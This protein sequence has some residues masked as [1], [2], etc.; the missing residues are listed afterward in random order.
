MQWLLWLTIASAFDA[1]PSTVAEEICVEYERPRRLA[2]AMPPQPPALGA[3]IAWV[4]ARELLGQGRLPSGPYDAA[5]FVSWVPQTDPPPEGDAPVRL[6]V[7][8][9]PHP[10]EPDRVLVRVGAAAAQPAVAEP[11]HVVVLVSVAHTMRSVSTR[12][13]P[14][15]Q[16]VVPDPAAPTLLYDRVDR[17][18]LAREALRA[19]VADLPPDS[20]L[21][22]AVFDSGAR[23]VLEPT[24]A[25]DG[26]RVS[27]AIGSMEAG[28][29][30][31]E[32]GLDVVLDLVGRM[33]SLC[34]ATRVIVVSDGPTGMG[35]DPEQALAAVTDL[36]SSGVTVSSV[37]IGAG[38]RPVPQLDRLAWV[39]YGRHHQVDTLSEAV[40]AMRAELG[41]PRWVARDLSV[42]LEGRSAQVIGVRPWPH[43]SVGLTEPGLGEG[44]RRSAIWEL[45]LGEH[46]T[47]EPLVD[48][49]WSASSPVAGEWSVGGRIP[50]DPS[51]LP[52]SFAAASPGLRLAWVAGSFADALSGR[53]ALPL[54][55]LT[56]EALASQRGTLLEDR[57]LA[58]LIDRAARLAGRS[59]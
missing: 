27:A 9:A 1:D 56:G 32:R 33:R 11:V 26:P 2:A 15:L 25:S 3:P 12:A 21:A 50:V 22:L 35:G 38:T 6:V 20:R 55:E 31:R 4:R 57:E 47:G 18:G 29:D 10:T 28:V 23:V 41:T 19:F 51:E 45:R 46:A 14:V 40:A 30:G 7:E 53:P 8:A 43:G 34:G 49:V 5:D 42:T 13:W 52:A 17:L 44:A 59:P 36:A 24:L 16:D 39:G 37:S 58:A 54:H 48:V